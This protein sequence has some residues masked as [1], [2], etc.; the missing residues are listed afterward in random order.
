MKRNRSFA[1]PV[2]RRAL[3][4]AV[5]GLAAFWLTPA[6]AFAVTDPSYYFW[7][8]GDHFVMAFKGPVGR[9]TF[10]FTLQR[11]INVASATRKTLVFHS[12][13][14]IARNLKILSPARLIGVET[15]VAFRTIGDGPRLEIAHDPGASGALHIENIAFLT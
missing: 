14:Y 13:E 8:E 12:G 9:P 3:M 2:T 11:A 6:A 7:A 5:P 10:S 1:P 4:Q 15:G